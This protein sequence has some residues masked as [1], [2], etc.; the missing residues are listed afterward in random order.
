[1]AR[2]THQR[3]GLDDAVREWLERKGIDPDYVD[4]AYTV[5]RNG[6]GSTLLHL[7]MYANDFMVSPSNKLAAHIPIAGSDNM[8]SDL[9]NHS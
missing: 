8:C 7:T 5:E 9:C 4:N 1:M 2:E 3:T 6:H